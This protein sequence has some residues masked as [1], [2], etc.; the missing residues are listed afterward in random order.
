PEALAYSSLVRGWLEAGR[1]LFGVCH[2][3]QVMARAAGA[4]VARSPAGWELGTAE[5]TLTA[6]GR[7]C[8]LFPDPGEPRR[9]LESHQDAVLAVPR[10][11]TLL[12]GNAHTPVQA[13]AYGP[14]QF[15]VQFHPEFTPEL[16]R[17]LWAERRETLR[18]A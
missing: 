1:P 5:I 14:R 18:E 10:N 7:A 9:F 2:G 17:L 3:H 6:A 4:E 13:L 12:G 16:L 8:P 11:A 15:S